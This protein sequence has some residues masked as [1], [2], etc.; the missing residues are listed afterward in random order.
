M[1]FIG[2]IDINSGEAPAGGRPPAGPGRGR[3]FFIGFIGIYWD[4][5]DLLDLLGFRQ[6]LL[7]AAVPGVMDGPQNHDYLF[8]SE[9]ITHGMAVI[10]T[11]P[12]S[13]GRHR[14]FIFYWIY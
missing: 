14:P 5:L 12:A 13:G 9:R 4:L 1:A 8:I 7:R 3:L 2:F 11:S 6:P 10:R